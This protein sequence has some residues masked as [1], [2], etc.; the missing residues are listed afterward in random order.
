MEEYPASVPRGLDHFDQRGSP[1]VVLY[2]IALGP[3]RFLPVFR[4]GIMDVGTTP[5]T[6][7]DG[8]KPGD[9]IPLEC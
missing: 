5:S 4:M 6:G 7:M 3:L 2:H 8:P 9:N 1:T